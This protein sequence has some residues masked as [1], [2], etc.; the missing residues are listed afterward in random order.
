MKN[1][2]NCELLQLMVCADCILNKV[3]VQV[4]EKNVS[5]DVLTNK[6]NRRLGTKM[7]Q[8]QEYFLSCF[9]RWV[10]PEVHFLSPC[11]LHFMFA[12][13]FSCFF[14][15]HASSLNKSEIELNL[16]FSPSKYKQYNH[17]KHKQSQWLNI[18]EPKY[19]CDFKCEFIV[20]RFC[21]KSKIL[22]FSLGF[23]K[24][25]RNIIFKAFHSG[26]IL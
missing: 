21:S 12:V 3:S 9:S 22:G 23:F 2:H 1:F 8:C 24:V 20:R 13:F 5:A 19:T 15:R 11:W 4:G 14:G 18:L 10:F 6:L 25:E 17:H 7:D 26:L 16:P